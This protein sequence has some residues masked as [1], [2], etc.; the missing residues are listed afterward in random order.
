MIRKHTAKGLDPILDVWHQASTLAH[1]FLEDAFVSKVKSD[2]R[3]LYLPDSE[4]W[5]FEDEG[6]IIGFI[7]MI[8]NE[9]GGLFVLPD[10]HSKG[11]GSS[12]VNFISH[13]H[14]TLEVEVFEKNQIG[15]AFYD[16]YGFKQTKS[17]YHEQSRQ[18]VLRL[19]KSMSR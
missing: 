18:E 19:A 8:E 14:P 15:R 2:M 6:I 9:I 13:M 16:K 5:V 7:S 1:P 10:H 4:T 3:N 11:I 12:L 17:Y